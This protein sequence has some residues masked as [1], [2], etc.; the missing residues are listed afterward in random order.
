MMQEE[1]QV[2]KSIADFEFADL[3]LSDDGCT[4]LI[5]GG[6]YHELTPVPGEYADDMREISEL[7][8]GKELSS[9]GLKEYLL[10]HGGVNY[11][12]AF[13][14]AESGNYRVLRKQPS[15]LRKLPE[16][17]IHP[18]IYTQLIT[19]DLHGLV[20]IAGKTGSGKTTTG[21]AIVSAWLESNGGVGITI[22]DPPEMPLEGVHGQGRCFQTSATRETGGFGEALRRVVRMAP[23]IILLGEI[24]DNETASEA[25]RASV[26]GHLVVATVHAGTPIE[27]I[28][29]MIVMA[30]DIGREGAQSLLAEGL[31]AVMSQTINEGRLMVCPL[32]MTGKSTGDN[33]AGIRSKIRKGEIQMLNSDIQ[34]QVNLLARYSQRSQS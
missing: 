24:R 21:S 34:T 31:T 26:N 2:K 25:L 4:G 28:E 10:K 27:A 3:Y 8:K 16:L 15:K 7:C 18:G 29:R 32:M 9:P 33:P 22:E 30:S 17:G 11:R 19:K 6:A 1:F 12:V 20:L 23:D 13:L 5:K 14:P